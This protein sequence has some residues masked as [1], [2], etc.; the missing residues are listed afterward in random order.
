MTERQ[1]DLHRRYG[2]EQLGVAVRCARRGRHARVQWGAH[3]DDGSISV[4]FAGVQVRRTRERVVIPGARSAGTL[5]VNC[6]IKYSRVIDSGILDSTPP[7]AEAN[8][9]RTVALGVRIPSKSGCFDGAKEYGVA[10]CHFGSGARLVPMKSLRDRLAISIDFDAAATPTTLCLTRRD[11]RASWPIDARAR[12]AKRKRLCYCNHLTYYGFRYDYYTTNDTR[13]PRRRR[14]N[15]NKRDLGRSLTPRTMPVHAST[16]VTIVSSRR[17]RITARTARND[18]HP[19]T[20]EK[21]RRRASATLKTPLGAHARVFDMMPRNVRR[22]ASKLFL[23]SR[24]ALIARTSQR[25]MVMSSDTVS[26]A[27]GGRRDDLV[28]RVAAP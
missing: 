25:P 8:G 9:E 21:T 3:D 1:Y 20:R 24:S 10:F 7:A 4:P 26:T 6:F 11:A 18:S 14:Y 22:R 12:N 28:H 16:S 13:S 15:A 17:A 2:Y 23:E 27:P 5:Y 19:T